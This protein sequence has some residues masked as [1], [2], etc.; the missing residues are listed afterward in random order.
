MTKRQQIQK[1]MKWTPPKSE[2]HFDELFYFTV[3]LTDDGAVVV[4]QV[5]DRPDSVSDELDSILMI[6]YGKDGEH[7]I[8]LNITWVNGKPAPETF[9]RHQG[10]LAVMQDIHAKLPQ[11]AQVELGRM[12]YGLGHAW[13]A[14]AT[15]HEE[16]DDESD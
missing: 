2:M 10:L 4:Q 3:N 12:A 13:G 5:E 15:I 8:A 11:E 9:E 16:H 1:R 14:H 7:G 6:H